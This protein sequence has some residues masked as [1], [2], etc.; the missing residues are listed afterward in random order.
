[1]AMQRKFF[2]EGTRT[3]FTGAYFRIQEGSI[4]GGRKAG[5][6]CNLEVYK[7]A[8]DAA[9]T[10][11]K[12]PVPDHLKMGK[13]S[14]QIRELEDSAEEIESYNTPIAVISPFGAT[15]PIDGGNVIP[16]VKYV[17][18][19]DPYDTLYKGLRASK[20]FADATDV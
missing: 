3:E 2:H 14:S 18:G 6:R 9:P 16:P 11:R 1:M 13:T 7:D 12:L 15:G 20:L 5:W 19:E 4:Q 8:Q 10:L 17:K